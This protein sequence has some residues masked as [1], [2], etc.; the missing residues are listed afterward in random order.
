MG[1]NRFLAVLYGLFSALMLASAIA[2]LVDLF[3]AGVAIFLILAG[4]AIYAGVV[5]WRKSA[6]DAVKPP[7][8]KKPARPPNLV[9]SSLT[10]LALFLLDAFVFNQFVVVLVTVV[11]ILPCLVY[12][13]FTVRQNRPLLRTRL[14]IVGIYCVMVLMILTANR[15]NNGIARDRTKVIAAACEQYK[16]KCGKY[17]E[18][19]DTLVPEFLKRIPSAK[20]SL[21]NDRFRYLSSEGSHAIMFVAVPPFGRVYYTLETQTW[22]NID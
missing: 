18:R 4:V 14:I 22:G 20:Y 7:G 6:A 10:A 16:T 13:S 15:I 2:C 11:A 19:L 12:R 8:E 17:P 5:R 21:S 1:F 3:Y 9:R